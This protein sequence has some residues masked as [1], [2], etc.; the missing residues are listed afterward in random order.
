MNETR[1]II[2]EIAGMGKYTLLSSLYHK[3]K[4]IHQHDN[5]AVTK[6]LFDR[7][8]LIDDQF[9]N[10]DQQSIGPSPTDAVDSFST[11]I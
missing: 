9:K 6:I 4:Q 5:V 10:I 3:V 8:A 1:V 7:I 11:S 2:V